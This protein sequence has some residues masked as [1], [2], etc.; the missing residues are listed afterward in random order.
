MVSSGE[1][2]SDGGSSSERRH[3]RRTLRRGK[4][5]RLGER[6]ARGSGVIGGLVL[7]RVAKDLSG[8]S[9]VRIGR[10]VDD[11]GVGQAAHDLPRR[12][13]FVAQRELRLD[14]DE[15]RPQPQRLAQQRV[16]IVDHSD[17]IEFEGEHRP[18]GR[19][20]PFPVGRH[21]D[22]RLLGR[23]HVTPPHKLTSGPTEVT[24]D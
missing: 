2:S 5:H 9:G 17:E 16:G 7:R 10:V 6:L 18:H 15:V 12:A 13:E 21:D 11:L 19:R 14:H 3:E 4:P 22:F 1:A 24:I 20:N 8:I 23:F